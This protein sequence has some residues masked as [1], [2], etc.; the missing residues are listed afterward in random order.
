MLIILADQIGAFVAAPF[1]GLLWAFAAFAARISF[2]YIWA[3]A[4]GLPFTSLDKPYT[5][6]DPSLYVTTANSETDGQDEHTR[7]NDGKSWRGTFY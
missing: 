5:T 6:P 4:K 7:P 3:K 1:G 2:Q